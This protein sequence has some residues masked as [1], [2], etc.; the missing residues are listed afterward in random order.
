MDDP[1]QP[2]QASIIN[3]FANIANNF[4]SLTIF[5]KKLHQ[6]FLDTGKKLNVYKTS[7]TSFER[8]LYVQFTFCVQ[9]VDAYQILC[10]FLVFST[11][12]YLLNVTKRKTR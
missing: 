10:S 12:I 3:I 11:D 2:C 9:D 7:R 6:T 4:Y 5:A 8:L 1:L